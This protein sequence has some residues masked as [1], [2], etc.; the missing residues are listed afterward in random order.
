MNHF[1]IRR[2]LIVPNIS[3]W[4]NLLRFEADV[5]ILSQ[6]GYATCIEI[7]VS[8]GDLKNDLKKPHIKHL[9]QLLIWNKPP[10]ERYYSSL[11]YFY[12]A[13]PERLINDALSQIPSFAGLISLNGMRV[14]RKP[15]KL[16]DKKWNEKERYSLA[17]LGAMRILNLKRKIYKLNGKKK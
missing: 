16:F 15:K 14:V 4:S 10:L 6:S 3:D 13:V 11:K 1:D 5:L 8:K 12:Y 7:K 2:N 9:D 17:R